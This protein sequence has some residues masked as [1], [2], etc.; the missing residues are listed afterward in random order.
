MRQWNFYSHTKPA[1]GSLKKSSLYLRRETP[2]SIRNPYIRATTRWMN[3]NLSAEM[4]LKNPS[5]SPIGLIPL[6]TPL[7]WLTICHSSRKSS[8]TPSAEAIKCPMPSILTHEATHLLRVFNHLPIRIS[9]IR[10]S[11]IRLSPIIKYRL[12]TQLA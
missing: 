1:L 10:V 3:V 9:L 7:Q 2:S 5:D 11:F 12:L 6:I 4:F 8:R